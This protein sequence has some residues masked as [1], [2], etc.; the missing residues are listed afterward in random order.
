MNPIIY[1]PSGA[2]L[3]YAPLAANLYLGCAHACAYCYAARMAVA[4]GWVTSLDEFRT[5]P[6]PK[7]EDVP[8]MMA[9]FERDLKGLSKRGNHEPV[10][11]SFTTDPYQPLE[12]ELGITREALLKMSLYRQRAMIL[13]KNPGLAVSR[14]L[15]LIKRGGHSLGV[16]L[17][18]RDAKLSR[19]FEPGA[20]EPAAR[21]EAL[22]DA[23]YR[24]VNTWISL[25]PLISPEQGLAVVALARDLGI[26]I[27]MGLKS[28]SAY[29]ERHDWPG[30]L[31]QARRI[32]ETRGYR[33]VD[34]YEA[35]KKEAKTYLVKESLKGVQ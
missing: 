3:E 22:A 31:G 16:T 24:G 34:A 19:A 29:Q 15:E 1:R 10:L 18:S 23:T 32:L 33:E 4:Y 11:L 20:P 26:H 28:G 25:E 7:K 14:D 12:L 6:R 17:T 9:R 5:R 27:A 35:Y 13:T 30:F 8:G 21:T 2:A